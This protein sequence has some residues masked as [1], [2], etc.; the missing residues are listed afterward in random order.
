MSTAVVLSKDDR[1]CIYHA[2]LY[3]LDNI[4]QEDT[5]QDEYLNMIRMRDKFK[6][7]CPWIE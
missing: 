3:W 7:L 2:V 6:L 1:Q 4:A 5:D